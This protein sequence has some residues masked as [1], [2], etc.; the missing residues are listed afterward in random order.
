LKQ[1]IKDGTNAAQNY[2]DQVSELAEEAAELMA[3][4][5]KSDWVRELLMLLN[6]EDDLERGTLRAI[7]TVLLPPLQRACA[8]V[9]KYPLLCSP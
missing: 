9:S 6:G 1:G 4:I 5:R 3:G 8:Q 2:R 7:A